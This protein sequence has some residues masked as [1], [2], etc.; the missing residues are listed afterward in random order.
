MPELPDVEHFRRV[1]EHATDSEI[2]YVEVRDAG[3]LTDVSAKRLFKALDGH[4]LSS[5]HRLG[6][7]LIV[8][9]RTPGGKHRRKDPSVIFHFGM[10]GELIWADDADD[11][12]GHRHDRI[13][14][15]TARGELRY[16]DQR[17]LQGVRLAA[18]DDAVNEVVGDVGPD[19][20]DITAAE[21]GARLNET[22]R[23]V[24]SALMDQSVVAGLGNLLA[25]EILW[26]ARIH[27]RT[28]AGD[29]SD[30][31]VRRV[32][33]RMLTVLRH[34]MADGRVPPRAGWLTGRRDEEDG[35]C[36]R[37]EALLRHTRIN[38]RRSVWCP[39]CQPQDKP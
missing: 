27:P 36:P 25:D 33:R 17:K 11:E 8:P 38:S 22:K 29:L 4:C 6:K 39:Q 32:H 31:D 24:K 13:V 9:V 20:A 1:A 21:L 37:C 35:R 16:R 34:S 23:Q 5:P 12:P 7:W 18:D 30:A 10:T 15:T 19:A 14:I 28:P 3:A 2:E 26:R